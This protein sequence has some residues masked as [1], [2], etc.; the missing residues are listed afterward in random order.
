MRILSRPRPRAW[1]NEMLNDVIY[2]TLRTARVIR[3]VVCKISTN[4]SAEDSCFR[5][6]W[7]SNIVFFCLAIFMYSCRDE[8]HSLASLRMTFPLCFH[9]FSEAIRAVDPTH[10]HKMSC[11][12]VIIPHVYQRLTHCVTRPTSYSQGVRFV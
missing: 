8:H 12:H 1:I 3:V 4:I 9:V 6:A 5:A 7:L 2:F 10:Y 11:N